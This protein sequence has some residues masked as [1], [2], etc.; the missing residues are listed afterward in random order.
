MK[1]RV[2]LSILNK[3]R[4]KATRGSTADEGKIMVM[5]EMTIAEYVVSYE[6]RSR[7]E[8]ISSHLAEN[9]K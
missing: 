1:I 6:G 5:N 3:S 2:L 8:S 4:R 7:E 9:R